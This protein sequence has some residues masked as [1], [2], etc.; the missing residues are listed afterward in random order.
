MDPRVGHRAHRHWSP[1]SEELD[2]RYYQRYRWQL[3][4]SRRQPRGLR[5]RAEESPRSI[6]LYRSPN[7]PPF[8]DQ[9]G[10][11]KMSYVVY[12]YE[13]VE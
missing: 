9:R 4:S 10:S 5:R 12:S 7:S 3:V 2:V 8:C 13:V 11:R 1:L 6:V